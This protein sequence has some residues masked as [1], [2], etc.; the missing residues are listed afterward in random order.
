MR[1]DGSLSSARV[2]G[3]EEFD[4]GLYVCTDAEWSLFWIELVLG[5]GWLALPGTTKTGLPATLEALHE[6]VVASPFLRG[7][8]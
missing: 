1:C 7:M 5:Q 6:R 3:I 4:D 8:P 2:T